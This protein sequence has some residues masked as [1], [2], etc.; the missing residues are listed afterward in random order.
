MDQGAMADY[1]QDYHIHTRFS[2]DS[3]ANM[4]TA[5]QMAI[6][7]GIDE[8][9][10][11]DHLDFGPEE[12]PGH[13][14][15]P[16]YLAALEECR[17]RYGGQLT[18]RAGIEVGEPHIFADE[19]SEIVGTDDFDVVLGS[20]HYAVGMKAAW[21]EG[22]FE[23]PLH[24]AYESYFSQVVDLAAEGDF[25]VLT[26][27]DLVKRD[28]RKFGRVYDGPGPYA[29]MI[30]TALRSLVERG[31]GLELNT[32]PLRRGQPEPCPS[33][34]ILCWYR[35]LGGEILVVGSDAHTPDAVGAHLDLAVE[36]AKSAGFGR[37]ATFDQ[38]RLDWV[39][40]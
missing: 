14:R 36:M 11:T 31:K 24:Q 18:I 22:F 27:I 28:A 23:Q 15:K 10:L 6:A 5:C 21:L 33:L 1:R 38:R 19:A 9:A 12:P 2:I 7:R 20:A 34:E 16:E 25:D 30:R 37:L 26:H 32:S 35:D 29:D 39:R 8:I 3:E 17:T 4:E 40:I 13:F